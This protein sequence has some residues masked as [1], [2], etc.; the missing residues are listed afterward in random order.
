Y[1]FIN[2]DTLPSEEEQFEAYKQVASALNPQPV[3]IRTLDLG[4]DKFLSHLQVPQ[5]MSPFLGWRAVRLCWQA[6]EI[7]AN[8]LRALLRASAHGNVKMMYPMISCVDELAQANKLVE[9]YMGELEKEGVPFNRELDIGAMI[10][11]P[12]AALGADA[13]AKR[14][15][16]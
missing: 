9:E 8:Q 7:F 1:L 6:Q 2:R 15:K 11:I 12:S 16:F 5:E 10:E 3:I 4:G 13:L 14:C